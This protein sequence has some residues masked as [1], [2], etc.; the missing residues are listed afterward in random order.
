MIADEANW[1]TDGISEIVIQSDRMDLYY[2]YAKKLLGSGNGYICSCSGDD[3]REIAKEKNIPT[4]LASALFR[5][6][7]IFFQFYGGFY[8]KI[9]NLFT[10][11]RKIDALKIIFRPHPAL[12]PFKNKYNWD[13]F[14][15]PLKEKSFEFL[16]KI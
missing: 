13:E 4:V 11:L 8:K 9:L 1:L 10:E 3:F 5:Q 2:S 7:Q 6:S 14:S 12:C 15:N 16:S